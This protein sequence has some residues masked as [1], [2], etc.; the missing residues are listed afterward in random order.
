MELRT[1]HFQ[2]A[3]FIM[4][5]MSN[6]RGCYYEAYDISSLA[7]VQ[8]LMD[9]VQILKKIIIWLGLLLAVAAEA[10]RI[11]RAEK[12][13]PTLRSPFKRGESHIK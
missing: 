4:Y 5:S 8:I 12:S 2:V 9:E 10:V 1:F 3:L 6:N 13:L 7:R 11:A